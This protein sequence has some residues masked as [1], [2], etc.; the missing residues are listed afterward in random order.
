LQHEAGCR[1]LGPPA[2]LGSSRSPGRRLKFD[3]E[4]HETVEA[5]GVSTEVPVAE[6]TP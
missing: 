5:L 2:A 1:R 3:V 6:L 4:A